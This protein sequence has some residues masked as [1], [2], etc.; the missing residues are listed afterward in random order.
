[1]FPD[2][3]VNIDP[4]N[5]RLANLANIIELYEN[6]SK[7]WNSEAEE[8]EEEARN[9]SANRTKSVGRKFLKKPAYANTDLERVYG[10]LPD[11]LGDEG[12]DTSDVSIGSINSRPKKKGGKKRRGIP[13]GPFENSRVR[14][15]EGIYL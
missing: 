1:M 8:E 15:L 11:D 3:E 5:K 14:D 2:E 4:A 10:A 12:S 9:S 6:Q 13:A 7:G